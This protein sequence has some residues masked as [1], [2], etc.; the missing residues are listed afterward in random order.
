MGVAELAL[1]VASRRAV[2][3][4]TQRFMRCGALSQGPSGRREIA[5]TFDDGPHPTWTPRV[6]EALERAHLKATF[7]VVG[8]RVEA[9][10]E[11]AREILSRG[12]EIGTHLYSHDRGTVVDDTTFSDELERCRELHRSLLGQ[13][14]RWLRFPY[15]ERG[16]QQPAKLRTRYGIDSVY[17]TFSSHD[18][19]APRVA[20]ILRRVRA[21]I[22]PGA[23]VLMHDALADESHVKPPYLADRSM[24]IEALPRIAELLAERGLRAV[25]ISDL[26]QR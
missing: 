17:W 14:L 2:V 1:A 7:F 25:T 9:Y 12:H 23:I 11:L 15:G 8:R 24:T 20:D 19:K 22:R 4:L 13:S 18:S 6:L 10:P 3:S 21:G 16:T 5:L 26:M